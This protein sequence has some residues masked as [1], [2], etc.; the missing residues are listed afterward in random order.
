MVENKYMAEEI[1]HTLRK[2][3]MY[4]LEE[5]G[6]IPIYKRT[7]LT[8]ELHE[9]FKIRTDYEIINKAKMRN[10]IHQTKMY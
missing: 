8:D 9:K 7:N 3:E 10:I 2:M 4:H 1:I 6:Y 5:H